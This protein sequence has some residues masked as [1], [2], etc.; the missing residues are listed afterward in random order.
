MLLHDQD[1][2]LGYA[3]AANNHYAITAPAAIGH[4]RRISSSSASSAA[5]AILAVHAGVDYDWTRR[6]APGA[7]S[8]AAFATWNL[9]AF[10]GVHVC[11]ESAAASAAIPLLFASD[12]TGDAVSART[13]I[14]TGP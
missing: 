9:A 7:S 3:L 10:V 11:G 13:A 14:V 1:E 12:G 5:G 2:S 6:V 8:A 4:I